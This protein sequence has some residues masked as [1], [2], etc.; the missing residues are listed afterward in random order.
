MSPLAAGSA[1]HPHL[2]PP[3]SSSLTSPQNSPARFSSHL[4]LLF[5]SLLR[6]L[7]FLCLLFKY[8]FSRALSSASWHSVTRVS[9]W[10][11]RLLACSH[12]LSL[13]FPP[14]QV[15]AYTCYFDETSP[16]LIPNSVVKTTHYLPS[17][18]APSVFLILVNSLHHLFRHPNPK[19][20][21]FI[22][23]S[24]HSQRLTKP[25]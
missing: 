13:A 10:L 7:S 2:H 8:V 17:K 16:Q 22:P 3:A 21:Y 11:W 20:R 15:P 23:H 19:P 24:S 14:P 4:R 12:S 5:L 18:L 6:W 9:S 1:P 25:Y